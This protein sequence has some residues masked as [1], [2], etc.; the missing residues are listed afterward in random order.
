MD[1]ERQTYYSSYNDNYSKSTK[2]H[3]AFSFGPAA[4]LD[5]PLNKYGDLGLELKVAYLFGG[6]TKYLTDPNIDNN[7][8]VSFQEKESR[9]D[10]LIP[11]VGIRI[12]IK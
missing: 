4:G 6:H 8:N 2:A 3:W 5:I 10:M 12:N 1:I 11:Q 9:T 7:A